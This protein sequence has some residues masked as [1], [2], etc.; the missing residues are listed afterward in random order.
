MIGKKYNRL[1]P[2]K[3]HGFAKGNSYYLCKCDCGNT[4]TVRRA[5][6]L[7]SH[8]KSCGCAKKGVHVKHGMIK[9]KE[10][11]TWSSMISRCKSNNGKDFK[12]YKKKGIKVCKRWNEFEKFFKDMGY[13]P[14]KKHSIDRI[15]NS[16]NYTPENCKWSTPSEQARNRDSCIYITINNK[17]KTLTEW[18][19]IYNI[20]YKKAWCRYNKG[21]RD[22]SKLFYKVRLINHIENLNDKDIQE[23]LL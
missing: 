6:L 22:I 2:I 8:T 12:T 16:G 15:N 17:T 13:A 20:S 10:Y 4:A 21:I 5:Y 23:S 7:N 18:C 9:T 11:N 14:S 19:E 1:T 3:F